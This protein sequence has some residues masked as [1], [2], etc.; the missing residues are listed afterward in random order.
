MSQ[1]ENLSIK[2]RRI[3]TKNPKTRDVHYRYSDFIHRCLTEFRI[4][5]SLEPDTTT[6]RL[7]TGIIMDW[8][9]MKNIEL[10]RE[11]PDLM[12]NLENEKDKTKWI[13]IIYD[14]DNA[15]ELD[16]LRQACDDILELGFKAT[17]KYKRLKIKNK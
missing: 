7:I 12:V 11:K 13:D 6:S 2:K 17:T 10:F 8:F 15:D 5:W 16:T 14:H 1:E 3:S 4:E 9:R